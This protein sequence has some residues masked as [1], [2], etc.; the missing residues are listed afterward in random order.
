MFDGKAVF[1]T[2]AS[3]G[4]GAA[5]ARELAAHG[6]KLALVARRR[7]RL[8]ELATKLGARVKVTTA[9][10]DVTEEGALEALAAPRHQ[11]QLGA[12]RGQLARQRCADSR[13]RSGDEHHLAVEHR[14][15]A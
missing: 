9:V 11:R 10:A 15:S 14:A 8:E 4:I 12:V 13:R 1:I 7:E 6:A 2:G 5:L 3:S